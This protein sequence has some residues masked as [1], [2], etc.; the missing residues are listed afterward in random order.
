MLVVSDKS[1][2][3][4]FW[5]DQILYFLP[6]AIKHNNLVLIWTRNKDIPILITTNSPVCFTVRFFI[7]RKDFAIH[8][9]AD[10]SSFVVNQIYSFIHQTTANVSYFTE[11][12]IWS[13]CISC[14]TLDLSMQFSVA[15][16]L[17]SHNSFSLFRS[18]LLKHWYL[19]RKKTCSMIMRSYRRQGL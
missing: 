3:H 13:F 10:T 8:G 14:Y 16:G 5:N 1:G 9:D 7:S 6:F 2:I 17:C 15:S 19:C 18:L 4:S 11:F 12:F